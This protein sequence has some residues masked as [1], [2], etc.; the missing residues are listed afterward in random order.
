MWKGN[1]CSVLERTMIH[2]IVEL[3]NERDISSKR[4]LELIIS[5]ISN[6]QSL[7]C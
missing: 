5:L 7:M 1:F 6:T 3:V 2:S 4:Y